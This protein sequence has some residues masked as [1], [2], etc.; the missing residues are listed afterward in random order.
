MMRYTGNVAT[1]SRV[2]L[3]LCSLVFYPCFRDE[4]HVTKT[5][6]QSLLDLVRKA[7]R[8]NEPTEEGST[9]RNLLIKS[10]QRLAASL[11][12]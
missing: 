5:E 9:F 11:G 1:L 12:T 2:T 8:Q 4:S 3:T 7:D 6:W 10:S